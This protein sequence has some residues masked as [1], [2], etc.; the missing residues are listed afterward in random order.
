MVSA[1]DRGTFARTG[2]T[3]GELLERWLDQ[4]ASD[5]SPKTV[6]ETRGT[7]IATSSQPW[8]T[9]RCRSSGR[10]TWTASI[11]TCWR[12]ALEVARC[13]PARS[14]AFTASSDERSSKG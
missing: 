11:A 10:R 4:A 5:Y 9:F 14:A 6:R 3:V 8:A 2:A 13:R 12:T 1:A 7:S